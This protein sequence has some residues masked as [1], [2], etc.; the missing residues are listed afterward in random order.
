MR[1]ELEQ[2]TNQNETEPFKKY[3]LLPGLLYGGR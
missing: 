1:V 3:Y 2:M